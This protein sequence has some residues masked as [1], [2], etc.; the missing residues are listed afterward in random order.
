M[1]GLSVPPSQVRDTVDL[2]R[3]HAGSRRL[4]LRFMASYLLGVRIQGGEEGG[5]GAGAG[6]SAAASAAASGH[7]SVED[8]RTALALYREWERLK[9]SGEL[10]AKVEEMYAW[11]KAHGWGPVVRDAAGGMHP[12]GGE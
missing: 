7:D 2:F 11:G 9:A 3:P 10:E 6:A 5:G 4:R 8:A 1:T 12:S